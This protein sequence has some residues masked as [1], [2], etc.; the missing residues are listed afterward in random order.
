VLNLASED[1]GISVQVGDH[2]T[3]IDSA[4]PETKLHIQIVEGQDRLDAGIV[5]EARPLAQALLDAEV[6][7]E[8]ELSIPGRPSH[9]LKVLKIDRASSP[10]PAI[11]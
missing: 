4:Q 8:V 6:G 3:Y 9:I 2:V 11:H 7:D 5:N 10:T 1:E